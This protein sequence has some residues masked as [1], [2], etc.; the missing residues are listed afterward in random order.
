MF[1]FQLAFLYVYTLY[2]IFNIY[3]MLYSHVVE[4][5]EN[6]DTHVNRSFSTIL[7]QR[8][9]SLTDFDVL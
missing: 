5:T 3:L 7:L 4:M 1:G 9:L 8:H 2:Y 6:K